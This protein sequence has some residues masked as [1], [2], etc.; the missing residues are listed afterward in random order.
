MSSYSTS[1]DAENKVT[2]DGDLTMYSIHKDWWL[3]E[4][5]HTLSALNKQ[6]PI[7]FNLERLTRIDS[8]GLAW[9]INIVRDSQA[10]G[11]KVFFTHI[12]DDLANLAKISDASALLP[13]Q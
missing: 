3:S 13:V 8:A 11:F 1:V 7:T 10:K 9:L 2:F 12:P 4:G 5:K 6:S